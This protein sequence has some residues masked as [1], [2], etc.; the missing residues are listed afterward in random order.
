METT[1]YIFAGMGLAGLSLAYRL[2]GKT[3]KKIILIDPASKNTNDRTWCFWEAG[4]GE[5]ENLVYRQWDH[6]M[7]RAA[8]YSSDMPLSP[9]RYKMIRS[10]DFYNHCLEKLKS[11]ENFHFVNAAVKH[12][13]VKENAAI[14]H[15]SKETYACEYVFSSLP[16]KL[17]GAT[18]K[19]YH[20]LWQH[21]KG[22][23]IETQEPKFN[24]EL[25]VFMDFHIDQHNEARFFYVLPMNKHRALVEFTVFSEQLLEDEVYDQ[26]IE[27]YL[28]SQLAISKYT[29]IHQEKGAIP[30]TDVPMP[31]HH[32]KRIVFMGTAGGQTKASTGYTFMRVQN[33]CSQLAHELLANN[34]P[35]ALFTPGFNRFSIFDST[36]L[37]VLKHNR[38]PADEV[39]RDLF[40]K[41]TPSTVLSFLDES[42]TMIQE[43]KLMW[44]VPS[45]P[46]MKG[47]MASIF[48]QGVN[49]DIWK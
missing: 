10:I 6:A 18:P 47:M 31:M 19:G 14:V 11:Y 40:K 1:D 8:G 9:Y 17:Q 46:F 32:E 15:T 39:F 28:N 3:Q 36:L 24:P 20:F 27:K 2:A 21:F 13:E 29:L 35:N 42:T 48:R 49:K 37:N 41:N 12:L 5:F 7:F 33:F 34:S 4:V 44:S 25:P 45:I 22:L 43:L 16:R 30:M 23:V 26:E 38:Y